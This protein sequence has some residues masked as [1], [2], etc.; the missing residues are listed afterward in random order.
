MATLDVIEVDYRYRSSNVL[1][2]ENQPVLSIVS[3]EDKDGNV[4]DPKKYQ[5]IQIEDPLK[6][7]MSSIAKAGIEFLF[8]SVNDIPESITITNEQHLIRLNTPA[9]LNFK[10][11]I[12]EDVVVTSA[13]TTITY[14]LGVDYT[15]TLGTQTEYTYINLIS[16]GMIRS[17]DTI[18]VN[19][20]ASTNLYV[21]YTYNSLI[22]QVQDQIDIMKHACA[23]VIAKQAVENSIDLSFNIERDLSVAAS[24][25]GSTTD[26]EKR[27]RSKIQT[28]IYN[29]VVG[30]KMGAT[31]TQGYLVKT[32]LNVQGVASVSTPFLIMQKREGSFIP[33]DDLGYLAFEVYQRA[34]EEGVS[35]YKTITT[36]LSYPT[37]TNGGPDNLFRAVYE[38][39]IELTLVSDPTL[40]SSAPGQ[41]Y[42][43][44]D[45]SLIVSTTDGMPPQAKHY[46]AAYYVSYPTGVTEVEDIK[47][48]QI[49]YL[50]AD[51]ITFKGIEFLN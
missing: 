48:S 9:Q 10:G 35:S 25:D 4:I 11:V 32:I 37:T 46:M 33:L 34:G 28:A 51:S 2:L 1:V 30:L 41:A 6:T 24:N 44:A 49:E 15:V 12:L 13:D 39:M 27:L 22:G 23:D 5:L 45:G 50:T 26:D 38:D 43:S 36:V 19:Y 42:I 21:T 8:D 7:G 20:T 17:G 29:A 18:G 47:T 16:N 3:V 31:L 14:R 40:V